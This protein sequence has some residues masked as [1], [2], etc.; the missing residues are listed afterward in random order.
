MRRVN[1]RRCFAG[2]GS[3]CSS[4]LVSVVLLL[5]LTLSGCAAVSKATSVLP[6]AQVTQPEQLALPLPNTVSTEP[7]VATSADKQMERVAT[8]LV[9]ALR[10]VNNPDELHSGER[11][12]SLPYPKNEF[13]VALLQA[14]QQFGYS[15]YERI[16]GESGYQAEYRVEQ[17]RSSDS[18]Q[19]WGTSTQASNYRFELLTPTGGYVSRVYRW[20]DDQ[21]TPAGPMLELDGQGKVLRLI[22]TDSSF[23]SASAPTLR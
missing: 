10:Y 8:D 2:H 12:V 16:S 9:F 23:F 13:D 4:G 15:I 22:E 14:F 20:Q 1:N 18:Q 6:L 5:A 3:N 17:P 21:V 7:A 19:G 11:R